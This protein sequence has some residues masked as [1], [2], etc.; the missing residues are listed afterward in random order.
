MSELY[1]KGDRNLG[2][3]VIRIQN[4]QKKDMSKNETYEMIWMMSFN[5]EK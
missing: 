5:N 4:K 2:R 3:K 1:D